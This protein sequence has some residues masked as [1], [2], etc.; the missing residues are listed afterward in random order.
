MLVD[1]DFSPPK[2]KL[3]IEKLHRL[4]I[5]H[6]DLFL[7]VAL[8][9]AD[10]EEVVQQVLV[11]VLAAKD[12]DLTVQDLGGVAVSPGWHIALLLAFE[13]LEHFK[14]AAPSL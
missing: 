3:P 5:L 9:E 7:L 12:V 10:D 6:R 2:L 11:G 4:A 14:V 8:D 1:L 13:P